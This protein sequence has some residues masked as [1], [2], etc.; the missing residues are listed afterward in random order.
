MFSEF[1]SLSFVFNREI[2]TRGIRENNKSLIPGPMEM[3]EIN[4]GPI[5]KEVRMCKR[6]IKI[7]MS[8]SDVFAAMR[9]DTKQLIARSS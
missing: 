1:A 9:E 5:S 7:K 8:L 6:G 3:I 4:L 2:T